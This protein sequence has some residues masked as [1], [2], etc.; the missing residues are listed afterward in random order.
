M[1][2]SAS[3]RGIERMRVASP[4]S[5]LSPLQGEVRSPFIFNGLTQYLPHLPLVLKRQ[6]KIE[7][8][9]YG[10]THMPSPRILKR[11]GI[12]GRWGR[13]GDIEPPDNSLGSLLGLAPGG[14]LRPR[15]K[16]PCK[17]LQK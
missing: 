7:K 8:R 5:P 6:R 9:R 10:V 11:V 16:P 4:I 12:R 13:G 14:G 3:I 2:K 17:I 1:A 15:L